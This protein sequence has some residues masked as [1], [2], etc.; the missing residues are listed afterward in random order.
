MFLTDKSLAHSQYNSKKLGNRYPNKIGSK[1]SST[2]WE[3]LHQ[4]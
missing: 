2:F 3:D 4:D 1:N